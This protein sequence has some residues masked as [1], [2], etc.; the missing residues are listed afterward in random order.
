MMKLSKKKKIGLLVGAMAIV[1]LA[2]PVLANAQTITAVFN[3]IRVAVNNVFVPGETF[4]YNDT[5]YLPLRAAADMVGLLVDFDAGTDTVHLNHLVGLGG[6][7]IERTDFTPKKDSRSPIAFSE[8]GVVSQT[9]TTM[10]GDECMMFYYENYSDYPI[11]NVRYCLEDIA[12]ST[13]YYI[14]LSSTTLPGRR[15]PMTI[16]F[17]IT[18]NILEKVDPIILWISYIL[19]DGEVKEI[20]YLYPNDTYTFE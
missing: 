17:D 6:Y 14:N 7:P 20:R 11:K 3:Q 15:S 4:Q 1:A 10:M 19:P 16:A 8:I 18:P 12:T 2:V 13:E 9:Y 5:T